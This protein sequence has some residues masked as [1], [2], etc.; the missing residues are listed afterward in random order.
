MIDDCELGG[1][2]TVPAPREHPAWKVLI[3][4]DDPAT[5]QVT[6][7]VLRDELIDDR[8][9]EL[10]SAH[11]AAEARELLRSI[12]D[13]ALVIV[14]V[15]MESRRAG[16]ELVRWIRDELGN[17]VARVAIRTGEQEVAPVA[18]VLK[19]YEIN[20]YWVK[21]ELTASQLLTK[22]RLG[23][24]AYRDLQTLRRDDL[25]GSGRADSGDQP[26]RLGRYIV[27]QRV[28][29]GGMG[30]VYA[31]YDPQLD[32]KV[33]V[34]LMHASD[35]TRAQKRLLREARAMARLSHPNVVAVH[36]VG[37]HEGRVF[38]AMDF[39]RGITLT[40]WLSADRRASADILQIFR[41]AGRGLAAAH[42]A[43]LVHRDFKPDNVLVGRRLGVKV[44]DFGIAQPLEASDLTGQQSIEM[45]H[46]YLEKIGVQVEDT[47]TEHGLIMGTPNYMAP[48]QHLGMEADARTDQFSF[49]LALWEALY[50]E[51]PFHGETLLLR[52]EACH[53]GQ[54]VEPPRSA[55]VPRHIRQA[56]ARGLSWE[57]ER[58][59]PSMNALLAQLDLVLSGAGRRRMMVAGALLLLGVGA[60]GLSALRRPG[61]AVAELA[62]KQFELAREYWAYD[63]EAATR[64][65]REAIR[66]YEEL[67]PAYNE[68]RDVIHRW[69]A[70]R[71]RT[72][73]RARSSAS[74]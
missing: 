25:P 64:H 56:L 46:S 59:W 5:H 10:F 53:N 62:E 29:T 12:H 57:K 49:A 20:D 71:G 13:L 47:H 27:L 31:A 15:V 50:G 61:S 43:G 48:E 8:P 73:D 38:V 67:G 60:L 66:L 68:Q 45:L 30:V 69:L 39:I 58:R 11:S 44:T 70:E 37:T 63:H 35:N 4:D 41:L 23:V 40:Q 9:V 33:A 28:G 2:T 65:A 55:G 22:I 3:V 19:D 17:N 54:I 34:K 36:D 6:R 16:L 72:V 52:L 21:T 74:P 42:D 14:D 7:L 32:R 18:E 1:S 24:R 26:A 51:K